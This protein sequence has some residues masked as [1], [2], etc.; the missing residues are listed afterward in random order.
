MIEELNNRLEV[1]KK[2]LQALN[3]RHKALRDEVFGENGTYEELKKEYPIIGDSP[4]GKKIDYIK[5]EIREV[6]K[7]ILAINYYKTIMN[8]RNVF[9]I[10]DRTVNT[11]NKYG[12][13]GW[14]TGNVDTSDLYP[15]QD[16]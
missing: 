12:Y 16:N 5:D 1:L 7:E 11:I 3:K 4:I 8:T 10:I 9:Q 14:A 6:Q 15:D 13:L 2:K